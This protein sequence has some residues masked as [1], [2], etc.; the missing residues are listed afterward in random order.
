MWLKISMLD[1]TDLEDR[2]IL[3]SNRSHLRNPPREMS[4]IVA[5]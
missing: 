2:I 4:C 1:S 3:I 5:S